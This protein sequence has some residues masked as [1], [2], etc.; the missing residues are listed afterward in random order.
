MV[1]FNAPTNAERAM[2]YRVRATGHCQVGTFTK[3]N[4]RRTKTNSGAL[5][6]YLR[7]VNGA[8]VGRNPAQF[9][10]NANG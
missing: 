1:K 6:A 4:E 3:I 8:V 2:R 10:L 5:G 7:S 9:G